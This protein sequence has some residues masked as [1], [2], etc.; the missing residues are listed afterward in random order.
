MEAPALRPES[1]RLSAN[2]PF[3]RG[4]SPRAK[5]HAEDYEAWHRN[6]AVYAGRWGEVALYADSRIYGQAMAQLDR[7]T[8]IESLHFP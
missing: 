2:N 3:L 7:G 5:A 8:P 6:D 1:D 4:L